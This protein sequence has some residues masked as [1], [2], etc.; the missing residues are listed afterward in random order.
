MSVFDE[1]EDWGN[2][3]AKLVSEFNDIRKRC[4]YSTDSYGCNCAKHV[5]YTNREGV[6]PD[7]CIPGYCPY[8]ITK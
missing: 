8:T 7:I 6:V 2:R 1:L 5:A 3:Y 4:P